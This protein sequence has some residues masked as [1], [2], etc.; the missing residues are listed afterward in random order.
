[1]D[2]LRIDNDGVGLAMSSRGNGPDLLFVHGLGSA[3]SLWSPLVA[4]LAD[5]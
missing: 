4:R 2:E 1:M 3:R 5:R